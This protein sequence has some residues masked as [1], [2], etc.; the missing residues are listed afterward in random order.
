[1]SSN[2]DRWT[3]K[4]LDNL[5]IPYEAFFRHARH[6]WHPEDPRVVDT[7]TGEVVLDCGCEQ[8]IYG[9]LSNGRFKVTKF[10]MD[11]E[12]SGTFI[13]WIL[14]PALEESTGRLEAVLIWEGGDV[15]ERLSVQDGVITETPIEL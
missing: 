12:G 10:D 8:G 13:E 9:I 6:D 1:M 7:E 15:I 14:K 2:I 5:V 4:T 3:T 11:G